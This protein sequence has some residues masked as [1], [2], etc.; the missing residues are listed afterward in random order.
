MRKDSSASR[1]LRA[2]IR[3]TRKEHGFA[4]EGFAAHAG[5][6]PP[7]MPPSTCVSDTRVATAVL[8]ARR[9]TAGGDTSRRAPGKTPAFE[10]GCWWLSPKTVTG[11]ASISMLSPLRCRA[12]LECGPVANPL[13]GQGD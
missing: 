2:A 12:K 9:A 1:A 8:C 4:Q 6:D 3:A 7:R 11:T 5:I 13:V 10:G